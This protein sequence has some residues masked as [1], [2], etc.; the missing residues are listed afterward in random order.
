V[1]QGTGVRV[2]TLVYFLEVPVSTIPTRAIARDLL[3][4]FRPSLGKTLK[5]ALAAAFLTS[6]TSFGVAS[7]FPCQV[8]QGTRKHVLTDKAATMLHEYGLLG[9]AAVQCGSCLPTVPLNIA[10]PIFR[11]V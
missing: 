9:C 10:T 3:I 5:Q 11:V 7:T 4:L 6:G 8:N 2:D 1:K